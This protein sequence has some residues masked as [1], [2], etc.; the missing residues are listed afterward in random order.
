MGSESIMKGGSKRRYFFQEGSPECKLVH[1][2][3]EGQL[4]YKSP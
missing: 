1:E 2:G 3:V 4:P